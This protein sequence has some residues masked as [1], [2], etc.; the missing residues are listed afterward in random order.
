MQ[1]YEADLPV[2][3]SHHIVLFASEFVEKAA[4]IVLLTYCLS[5]FVAN[6]SILQYKLFSL[7]LMVIHMTYQI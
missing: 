5:V 1:I 7:F 3:R 6:F 2:H 4:M